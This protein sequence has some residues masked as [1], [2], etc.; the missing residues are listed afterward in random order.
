MSGMEWVG[1]M[2]LAALAASVMRMRR[3]SQMEVAERW[4]ERR[5]REELEAYARVEP[6]VA[7]A[8]GDGQAGA[9]SAKAM[10][11][12]VCRMVADKSA[13]AK[14]G[15]MLRDVEGRLY[16]A[17]SVGVDDLTVKAME[18]W[19]AKVMEEERGVV[20]RAGQPKALADR[21]GVKSFS[22]PLGEWKVFDA[23]LVR[24]QLEGKRERRQYRRG[25]VAPVR[26]QTGKLIGA[27]VVCADGNKEGWP[28]GL[29]RAMGGLETLA[30]RIAGTLENEALSERVMRA[31]KLAGLGQLA[32]GVAHALNNPLT[33]VMGFAELIAET[34]TEPRVR[35]DAGVI[36]SEALKMRDTVQR[37][38]EFWRPNGLTDETVD[39]AL[40]LR[41]VEAAC[42]RKLEQRGVR[43]ALTVES[44]LPGVKGNKDRLKQVLEHLLNNSAQAIATAGAEEE[45]DHA[46]R[47]TASHDDKTIHL[48]VSDTGG[49][50]SEPGRVFDPF[51]TTKQ[52][53]Q[54]PAGLGLSICYGIVREHGGEISAFNL[55]P[56]GA[57]VVVELPANRVRE[58][59]GERELLV[60]S[61]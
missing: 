15:M 32:G 57:A 26:T 40:V 12:R 27:I 46:I 61:S 41:E 20:R 49:G 30:A 42:V 52:Q 60:V 36:L 16:C 58:E 4:R 6:G 13:F 9:A 25:I 23:A 47:I 45:K 44:H 53:A 2:V 35:K 39:V 31:E 3:Q 34:A 18:N 8:G 10:A 17:G 5:M 54:G 24:R 50:F 28:P 29:E 11:M 7:Q 56:R 33:A 19:G 38:T 37:L 59:S 1:L 22:I 48:I 51:Y 43:L 55:H 21:G 14:V